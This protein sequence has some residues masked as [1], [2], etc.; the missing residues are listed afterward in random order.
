MWTNEGTLIRLPRQPA[1][2]LSPVVGD[3]PG[4]LMVIS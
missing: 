4:G 3:G 1:L 2:P